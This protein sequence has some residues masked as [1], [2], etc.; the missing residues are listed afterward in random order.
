MTHTFPAWTIEDLIDLEYF[1]HREETSPDS[2]EKEAQHAKDRA[3]YL[4]H[5]ESKGPGEQVSRATILRNWLEFRRNPLKEAHPHDQVLPGEAFRQIYAVMMLIMVLAGFSSGSGLCFSFLVYKGHEPLNVSSYL[6]IFVLTQMALILL[7]LFYLVLGRF[8]T[9][10]QPP[11]LLRLFLGSAIVK[12]G[13]WIKKKTSRHLSAAHR[14]SFSAALG[15]MSGRSSQYRAVLPWPLIILTQVF[16]VWFNLGVLTATLLKVIGSDLAFG[17]QSTLQLSTEAVYKGAMA[18]AL[19][20]SWI[21][22]ENLAHPTLEQIE[23][24]RIILKNGIGLLNSPDLAAWW[25]FLCFAVL[26]YGLLPRLVLLIFATIMK[27]KA[28]NRVSFNRVSFDKLL[29]SLSS[30]AIDTR[31]EAKHGDSHHA[32]STAPPSVTEIE[33]LNDPVRV[34][35]PEDIQIEN[36]D[37]D[38]GHHVMALFRAPLSHTVPVTLDPT[39]DWSHIEK[40]IPGSGGRL[41]LLMESWQPP[42]REV[43]N[44]IRGIKSQGGTDFKLYLLMTGKPGLDGGLTPPTDAE[45]RIWK[46]KI[47]ALGDPN[48]QVE[49]ICQ[50]L[51]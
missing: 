33:G 26:V 16:A 31:G 51:K 8:K 9:S 41:A 24:S 40:L 42:I 4:K 18:L 6:G 12:L 39:L 34:L 50:P 19:P 37:D 30:P 22:P 27:K 15:M 3:F 36:L 13:V 5:L 46:E 20:W 38:L 48:I 7:V 23:G 28:L 29:L 1:I 10:F 2:P 49:Q 47:H 32:R 44:Y 35:V 25:P 21:V 43:L 11:S 17:W 45:F 14:N